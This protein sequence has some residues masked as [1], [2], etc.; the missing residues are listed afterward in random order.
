MFSVPDQRPFGGHPVQER[1]ARRRK[2]GDEF[3]GR[4]FGLAGKT[5]RPIPAASKTVL[6]RDMPTPPARAGPAEIQGATV[7]IQAANRLRP[8]AHRER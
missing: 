3:E 8:S 5:I 4:S 1:T 6:A 7:L 2:M